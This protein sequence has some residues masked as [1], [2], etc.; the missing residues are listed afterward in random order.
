MERFKKRTIAL[1]LASVVTV[2]GAF[3]ADNYKNSL[4]GLSFEGSSAESLNLVVKTKNAVEGSITP[5]RKDA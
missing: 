2:V 3:G 4:T 1:V 5:M